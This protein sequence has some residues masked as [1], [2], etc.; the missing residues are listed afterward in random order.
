MTISV[1]PT[2]TDESGQ[3]TFLAI[4]GSVSVTGHN[5][6]EAVGAA[7]N[8][9]AA[10]G[11]DI[12]ATRVIVQT[13]GGD[14]FFTTVQTARLNE[15]AAKQRACRDAGFDLPTDEDAELES[16]IRAEFIAMTERAKAIL[17]ATK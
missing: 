9:I 4:A 11:G 14:R 15:L 13:I 6:G 10:K 17:E 3:D 5:I 8:A 2:G 16:L 1:I 12:T 7:F